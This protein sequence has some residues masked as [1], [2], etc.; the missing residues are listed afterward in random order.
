MAK[1]K[2][3]EYLE[4]CVCKE[5]ADASLAK[6]GLIP[7]Q[8][9]HEKNPKW[10]AIL[11]TRPNCAILGKRKN[12][13]CK[14]VIKVKEGTIEWL[15]L[16]ETK[17]DNEPNSFEVP[18]NELANFNARIIKISVQDNSKFVQRRKKK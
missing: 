7:K 2:L 10:I 16:Y 12:Y 6:N 9:P 8:F 3:N 15:R 13:A 17:P 14:L 5:E 18:I 1:Q 4:R 11:G